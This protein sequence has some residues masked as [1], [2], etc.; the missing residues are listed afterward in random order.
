[1]DAST[2]KPSHGGPVLRTVQVYVFAA[3]V[4]AIGFMTHVFR[5]KCVGSGGQ[6][7]GPVDKIG[8]LK[9]VGHSRDLSR[10]MLVSGDSEKV[11]YSLKCS[12]TSGLLETRKQQGR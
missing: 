1:M 4:L 12:V 2:V 10:R 8:V 5:T 9:G 6:T 11:G 3:V 7:T